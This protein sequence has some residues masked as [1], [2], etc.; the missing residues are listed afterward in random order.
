M[1]RPSPVPPKRCAVVA[2]AWLNSCEQL[3]L[4]LRRHADAGIGD[5]KLDP[6]AAV[7]DPARPQRDLALLGELAGIAQEIEQDLP[8][9]HRDRRSARRGSPARRRP[10]GSCSARRAGARCRSPRRSAAQASTD[11]GL[12]SSLP[13]SILERSSTWLMRPSRWLPAACTRRSG[14]CAFSV[15][16]RAALVTI[17]SVSPMMALSGVRSSWLMLARNCDLCWLASCELPALVLDLREQARVLDRQH[18]LRGEGL[19]AARSCSSG[20]RPA[21]CGGP[22]GLPRSDRGRAR[23]PPD[24]RDNPD[25]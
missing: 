19:Q 4:L 21:P 2:S 5:G 7:A 6:A 9:P 18:R 14:S 8:Q 13:A 12:S 16:K 24:G 23:E 11:S 3:R 10:A 20:T 25:A 17:I 1:A 15:P 22:P